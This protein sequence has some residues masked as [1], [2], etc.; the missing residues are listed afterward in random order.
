M[1]SS[2]VSRGEQFLPD[3]TRVVVATT[4]LLSFISFWR[5]AAIVLSDL[6]SS[7]YYIGGIAEEAIGKSAPWF[8]LSVMLFSYA[9]RAVYIE[10]CS[11]F[12]R[13]GVYR[14]VKEAMGGTLAKLSV[15]ALMFD[16]ILTGPISSVSAGQY[17]AG[18]VSNTIHHL[19]YNTLSTG[20]LN[21]IAVGLALA[22]T[23][24]FW[25]QNTKGLHESSER[26][27]RIMQ[28]TTVMVVL[29]ICWCA[30]TIFLRGA[31]LPPLPTPEH[32]HFSDE[33][34][35]WLRGTTLPQLAPLALLVGFGHSIL[36]M[37]GEE[38]LAQVN[39]E[40]EHPK[41]QNLRRAG[42]VIFI[43]SLVFTSLV[44]FFAVMLI[45]DQVRFQ[46]FDNLIG[47]LAMYVVGPAWLR[48]LLQG[49]V[50]VVGF[51]I[52]AG[53]VNTAIVG[54]NGV[55]NRVAEDGVLSEWFR[56]PHQRFGTTSRII[57]LVV[58]LQLVT[59][60]ISSGRV[61]VLGEAYAFGVVWSFAFKAL[62]V[63]VLRF[64]KPGERA[65][66]VPLNLRLGTLELPVGLGL[67][68]LALFAIA[69]INGVTKQVAT[70]S[71]L[72]FTGVFFTLFTVS[73]RRS[74]R[75]A[76]HSQPLDQFQLVQR[77]TVDPDAIG[78]R[79]G[80]VLVVARDTHHLRSLDTVLEQTET[81]N[82]DV[83]VLTIKVMHSPTGSHQ[84]YENE[85]FG[86]YEQQ[87]FTAV[88]AVAEHQGKPVHLLV[89]PSTNLFQ[90]IAHTAFRLDAARI[91]IGSSPAL[92]PEKQRWRL[93]TVWRQI[94]GCAQRPLPL[95]VMTPNGHMKTFLLGG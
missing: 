54:S 89:V 34:L 13:G 29:M 52:L 8:I 47:G 63:L 82:Q 49:F 4:V 85:V 32:I 94:P 80:C 31:S 11:M 91:V 61:Y 35:G 75:R 40:I 36:A 27:L 2:P 69:M 42:L 9:V 86:R 88:V 22:I 84:F 28:V 72:L 55:L 65:W 53:A 70:I 6:A 3:R 95:T 74:R 39:R 20:Q 60:L 92:S 26:A 15:S 76:R 48:L 1:N 10:S 17:L 51:L 87:L 30:V 41:I 83:V 38:S 62:A 14:V 71:G 79:P 43:Y 59:I 21:A 12:T 19:G 66:R 44:S 23:V 16:Y 90:G 33:A 46:Y 37:S 7:A 68:T 81:D 58:I 67:I 18:L 77:E 25:W 24:Y 64:T 57:N 73:E 93:E 45:P 78:C 50:V 5:A 56:V